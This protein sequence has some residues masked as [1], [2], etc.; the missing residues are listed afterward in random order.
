MKRI[1][2]IV[3][4]VLVCLIVLFLYAIKTNHAIIDIGESTKFSNEERQTAVDCVIHNI[5]GWSGCDLI[6]LWYDEDK[7]NSE[8]EDYMIFGRGSI[9]GVIKENVI[10]LFAD[11]YVHSADGPAGFNPNSIYTKYSWTL[12]RDSKTGSWR[13]EDCGY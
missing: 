4:V 5:K 7:S 2:I 11:F 10:V 9:N 12:I 8:I 1:I 3:C 13:I 6:R